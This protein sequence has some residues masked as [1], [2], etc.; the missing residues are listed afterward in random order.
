MLVI[1]HNSIKKIT[2]TARL[3]KSREDL[4]KEKKSINTKRY[5]DLRKKSLIL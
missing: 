5:Y 2:I 1:A 3:N 4:A